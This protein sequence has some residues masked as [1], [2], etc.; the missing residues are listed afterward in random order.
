MSIKLYILNLWNG[1][2]GVLH[3]VMPLTM[4]NLIKTKEN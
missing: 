1:S 3:L 2:W 4:R